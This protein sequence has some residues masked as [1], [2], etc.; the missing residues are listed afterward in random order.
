MTWIM[1]SSHSDPEESFQVTQK[2]HYLT[3]SNAQHNQ[4]TQ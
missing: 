4:K 1:Q 3:S 2:Q